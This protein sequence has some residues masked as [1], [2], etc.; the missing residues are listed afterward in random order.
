MRELVKDCDVFIQ[1][2]RP[3]SLAH[4]GFSAADL[5]ALKPGLIY[6]NL[7]AFGPHGPWSDRRGFDSLVQTCSGM[8]VSEAEHYGGGAAARPMP[9]Q[10][11]D[12]AGGFFLATGIAAALYKRASEGGCWEVHVSLAGLMKYLRSL[13]Q[14]PGK[15]GFE[16]PDPAPEGGELPQSYFE[17]RDSGFGRM[18]GLKH[19]AAVEG[20][21]PGFDCMSNPPGIDEP[22]WL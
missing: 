22:R 21:M 13:G 11:L 2:Y 1:G 4:R 15:E 5:V 6:A 19:A 9:C 16:H 20:A 12:H 8:N 14:Y 7:S 18:R 10:A 3:E 17:E